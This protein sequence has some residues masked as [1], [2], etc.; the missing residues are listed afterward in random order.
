MGQSL[1]DALMNGGKSVAEY[2]K[3]LFRNLV[4]RPIIKPVA[5]AM[6]GGF[7]GLFGG[8]AAAAGRAS[9][10]P[11]RTTRNHHACT[12]AAQHRYRP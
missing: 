2:L 8:P 3:G 5:T 1:A 10:Y 9:P 7:M 4:L 6:A 12:D 11:I